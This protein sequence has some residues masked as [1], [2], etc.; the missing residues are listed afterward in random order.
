MELSIEALERLDMLG[1]RAQ[2]FENLSYAVKSDNGKLIITELRSYIN[3][4]VNKM[5]N[6]ID[7]SEQDMEKL[8]FLHVQM[9]VL[10]NFLNSLNSDALMRLK[11]EALDEAEDIKLSGTLDPEY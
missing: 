4:I 5:T 7:Y 11:Q 6:P 9:T 1:Q 10:N 2:Y 3:D 8:K